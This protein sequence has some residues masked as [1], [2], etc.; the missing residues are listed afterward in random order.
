[1]AKPTIYRGA[2]PE[3]VALEQGEIVARYP[4]RDT[5]GKILCELV[6]RQPKSF[7]VLAP[8][9]HVMP[10]FPRPLVFYR[11]P[12][13]LAAPKAATV[14]VVEGEK[15]ADR[16]AEAGLVAVTNPGG[17]K[18]SWQS[19]YGKWLADRHVVILPDNDNPGRQHAQR[20]AE[21]LADVAASVIVLALPG[22]G[23][24]QD[25]SDWLDRGKTVHQLQDLV[26]RE[27]YGK[28][29]VK[30]SLSN[31]AK[32]QLVFAA[33]I[34]PLEKLVLLALVHAEQ[35]QD[36]VTMPVQELARQLGLHR[37]T[38]QRLITRLRQKGLLGTSAHKHIVTWDMVAAARPRK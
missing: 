2:P 29:G 12:E 7:E 20:I 19:H 38:V 35:G 36:A 21:A 37:V 4:Y 8:D 34:R 13:L 24:A 9:G 10:G 27:R 23:R 16:L 18:L 26:A 15:D 11:L 3:P 33:D 32:M 22:L 28:A 6:R 5:E 30:S 17:T 1:M 25:V 31:R 14:F